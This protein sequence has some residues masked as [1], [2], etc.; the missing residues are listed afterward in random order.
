MTPGVSVFRDK[1]TDRSRKRACF[2][3]PK[4]RPRSLRK[5]TR[6]EGWDLNDSAPIPDD[7]FR[8]TVK[9]RANVVTETFEGGFF[10]KWERSS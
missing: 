5:K 8:E 2:G 9:A 7:R 3:V 1:V 4:F 6:R 10:I